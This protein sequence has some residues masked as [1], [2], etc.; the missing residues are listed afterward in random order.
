MFR[1]YVLPVLAA[2]GVVL[3]ISS[4]IHSNRPTPISPAVAEPVDSPFKDQIAGS[5][6]VEASTENIAISAVVPGVV[7]ELYVAYGDDV[8]AGAPLF[9]IDDRDLQ[10]E[11]LVR[12][13]ALDSAKL[14]LHRL[15]ASPRAEDIPPAQA[16]VDEADAS[17]KD[18]ETQLKLYDELA[19]KRAVTEDEYSRRRFA[20]KVN[21]ARL[22]QAQT[23][24]TELLAGSWKEDIAVAQADVD[25]AAAE[26]KQTQIA[27]DRCTVRAPV[28]GRVLQVKTHLGEFA[29]AG[30][31]DQPLILLGDVSTLH[32]RVDIDENDA[33]RLDP[34]AQAFA[35]L[36]G[37]NTL[38]TDLQYVRTE[39]YV[40]PKKSLT[41][42]STERVDTRVLQVIYSFDP[43]RLPVFV[44]QQVDVFIK[45]SESNA[46]TQP[47][48]AGIS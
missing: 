2:L 34:H 13:A 3:A 8:K 39:P 35:C 20:V 11:L 17:L 18:S 10:A 19:D 24:L 12:Q 22:A 40:V 15:I 38:R 27:I 16:R 28:A 1:K 26:V 25:S 42:D 9:K 32:V 45:A 46:A 29:T 47:S 31:L 5:G 21:Q 48:V 44:G 36:R 33:W 43:A 6:I 7:T 14:K 23:A 4:V 37:N 41:G 30:T